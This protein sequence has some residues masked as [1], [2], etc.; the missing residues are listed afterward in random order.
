[1][2]ASTYTDFV[3]LRTAYVLAYA[4]VAGTSSQ[5]AFSPDSVGVNGSAYV[6]DYFENTGAVIPPGG[7][8]TG[9]V[10]Y[11][12]SYYVVAPIGPSG[13]AFLGDAGK[14]VSCGKKRIQELL[15]NGALQ[16]TIQFA[17]GEA[18]V[19]LH[20][21]ASTAPHVTASSGSVGR[22]Q[23]YGDNLYRVVVHPDKNGSAAITFQTAFESLA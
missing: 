17:P 13:V 5:I 22:P 23:N 2:I 8:F 3:G 9:L 11:N 7:A 16:V 15:D 21:Y 20:L 18:F 10:D 1:M 4:T 19:A 14:F 12:G 6:Y